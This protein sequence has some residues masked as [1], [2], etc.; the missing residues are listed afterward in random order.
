[1]NDGILNVLLSRERIV[2]A[3][4]LAAITLLAWAYVLWLAAHMNVLMPAPAMDMSGMGDMPG[5]DMSAMMQPAFVAWTL[6]HFLFMFAMWAVMM[7]GMMTPS[8]A[9]MILIYAQV[10]HQA[11]T[12]GR[13]FVSA[14]WFASGYLLVWTA[15]ALLATLAQWG[16]ERAALLS[17]MMESSSHIFGGIVLIAAGLFQW[18]PIKQ[19]CLSHCR[20]PLL[21]VQ[22]HGGFKPDISGALRLGALHGA[23]CVGCCWALMALLFVGGVMNLLWIAGLMI[24]VLLEKI[25][26]GS[27]YFS[28]LAGLVAIAAGVWMLIHLT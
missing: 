8:A 21:F 1:M 19:A 14:A 28:R 26:P 5:M 11:A 16:L 15:F 6:P 27:R 4:A 22:Q 24:F 13:S 12:L 17:P 2:V 9:P 23:Y 7:V 10:A 25:I 20:A 3:A 18:T